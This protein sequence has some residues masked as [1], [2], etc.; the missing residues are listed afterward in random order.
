MLMCL[1]VKQGGSIGVV[2]HA[3]MYEPMSD[4]EC[5]LEAAS[6]AFAFNIGWLTAIL[7]NLVTKKTM[8]EKKIIFSLV[9]IGV[10]LIDLI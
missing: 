1:Q 7:I 4:Q 9:W 10:I 3:F 5:D 6:R 2:V 8:D